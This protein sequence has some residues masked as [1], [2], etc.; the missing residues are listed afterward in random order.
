MVTVCCLNRRLK[1]EVFPLSVEYREKFYA[2]G[3]IPGGFK[4][5]M[6]IRA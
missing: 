4:K 3:R 1:I 6:A 5:E 2:S